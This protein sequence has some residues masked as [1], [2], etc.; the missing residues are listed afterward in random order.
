MSAQLEPQIGTR[1]MRRSDIE[2]VIAIERGAYDYPW[3]ERIFLD[4]L[5]V[6]YRAWV[7]VDAEGH[8]IGYTLASVVV[9]E[10]HILN[11]CLAADARGSG[12]AALLLETLMAQAIDEGAYVLFLEVRPSNRAARR[13]YARYG[14]EHIGTRPDYYPAGDGHEDAFLL[15]RDLEP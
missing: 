2:Q 14:F 12:A 8:V 1:R 15:S 6:G 13:L 11:L 4:C 3:S 9:G 5:R 10:A 7:A